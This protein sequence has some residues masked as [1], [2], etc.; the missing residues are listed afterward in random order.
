MDSP[1]DAKS[2]GAVENGKIRFRLRREDHPLDQEG[3]W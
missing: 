2:C 1:G 3:S